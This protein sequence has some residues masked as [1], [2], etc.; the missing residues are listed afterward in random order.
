MRTNSP[1]EAFS[2]QYRDA[3]CRA[4]E[5]GG[6]AVGTAVDIR[7]IAATPVGQHVTAEAEATGI[8][9]RR[10]IFGVTARDEIEEIG[11]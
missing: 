8:E 6:S 3:K 10:I 11:R 2:D 5:P 1:S 9:G 7:H 4:L